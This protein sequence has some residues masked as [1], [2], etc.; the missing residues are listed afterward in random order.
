MDKTCFLDIALHPEAH[1]KLSDNFIMSKSEK[2]LPNADVAVVYSPDP[3]WNISGFKKLKLITCHA[4][5]RDFTDRCTKNGITVFESTRIWRTV[6]EHTVALLLSAIR[7]IPEANN[8]VKNGL[9]KNNEDLKIKHSGLDMHGKIV[10]IWGLGK[11]GRHIAVMMKGFG[12]TVIYNDIIRLSP[13]GEYELNVIFKNTDEFFASVDYLL[14][15]LPLNGHTKGIMNENIFAK[16]KKSIVLINTARAGLIEE[17]VLKQAFENG[18]VFA[19]ALDVLWNEASIQP[20]WIK[21]NP[22]IITVPHLGGSTMECDM[23]LVE[24]ALDLFNNPVGYCRL[25]S[26]GL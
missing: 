16:I 17:K 18:K 8:D 1:K 13:E 25:T 11:I 6:A 5:N 12:V 22:K 21:D 7:D 14:A 26:I 3:A 10:G 20:G 15:A 19:C 23:E 2:D 24:K 4:S 9:W